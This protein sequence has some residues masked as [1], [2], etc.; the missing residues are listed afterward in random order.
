VDQLAEHSW[1]HLCYSPL[2]TS[3]STGRVQL[4]TLL[5]LSTYHPWISWQSTDGH[6]AVNLQSSPVCQLAEHTGPTSVTLHSTPVCQLADHSWSYFSYSPVIT[7][8]SA[9]RAHWSHFG[10]SPLNTCVSTGRVQLVTLLLLSTHHPWINWQ[11]TAGHTSVTLQSSPVDQLAKHSWSHFCYSPLI[12]RGSADKAQLVTLLLLSTHHPWINW[13]STD[14][15]TS[16]TLQ[17]SRVDQLADHSWS[18]FIYSPL[19]TRGSAGRIQLVTLL[20]LSTHHPWISWQSTVGHTSVT[21]HSS[22]VDQLAE[23]SWSQFCYSSLITRG[24]AGRPQLV[25]LL[26]LSSHHPCFSWQSTL[27]T[28]WLLFAEHPCV[29]WQSTLV[30]LLS[31][32]THHRGSAGRAQLVTLLLLSSHHLCVSWQSTLV[33]LRLLS[34]QHPCV[35][36]QS[37]AGHTSV[38]LQSSPV[39][40][41]A[42]HSWSLYCYSK[43]ITRGSAG[44]VQLITLRLLST[45]H[46][47][48]SWQSTAGH[49]SATFHSSPVDQLAKHSW[50]H[51][52]YSP[53]VTRG[54]A[55]RAQLVTLLLLSTHHPWIC[56]QS[57]AG[58][59]SVTLHSSPV[60]QLAKYSWSHFRYFPLITHGSA[61][62]A[63]LV[64][65]LLLSTHNPWISWQS[66]T[67]HTSATLHSQ[68]VDQLAEYVWSH[69]GYSPVITRGSAG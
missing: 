22:P 31:L 26:L 39:D 48:N 59:T 36:W 56:W 66:T 28:L 14:G 2:I 32:S 23:Y 9:G 3:K 41:L 7:R 52:C 11:S 6:S 69:F 21:L 37:T 20:L 29:S 18:H 24:S 27:V 58:H 8:V 35:S 62:R 65:L 19:I 64:T 67:G 5:L 44:R 61:G 51:F 15:H 50:S 10:C 60:D 4:V 54:S 33:T 38:T 45:Y 30:T 46:P 34:T 17:S 1:S 49:T 63:Q 53:L 13:Q 16:V 12:T 68:P 40:Q 25:T 47:W 57:T 42:K 43:H 55:G